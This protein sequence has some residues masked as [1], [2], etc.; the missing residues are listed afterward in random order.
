M[1]VERSSQGAAAWI[2]TGYEE[3]WAVGQFNMSNLETLQAIVNAANRARSPVFVGTSMGTIRYAGL[4][5]IAGMLEAARRS[6]EV[7]IMLHLDHGPDVETIEACLARGYD[8]VMIDGSNLPFEDNVDLVRKVVE[9]SRPLGVAVEAQIG[10]TWEEDGDDRT[11][12]ETTAEEAGAFVRDTEVDYLAV[13]VGTTPGRLEGESSVDLA[14]LEEIARVTEIPLVL[15][16]GS[17]VPE[18]VMVETVRLGAAKV[19]IDTAIRE[20]VTSSLAAFYGNPGYSHD[21]RFA[22]R[23]AREEAEKAVLER[24]ELLGSAGRAKAGR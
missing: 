6:S 8:S 20:A 9:M 5:Y 19:N 3:G 2:R 21:P 14:L 13:S 12:V 17:S 23:Q 18:H 24:I 4:D 10:R 11:Q 22:L 16:G 15:H 7:P 1:S